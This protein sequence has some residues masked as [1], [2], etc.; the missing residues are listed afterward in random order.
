MPFSRFEQRLREWKYSLG[1]K[2][3]AVGN[4]VI[5]IDPKSRNGCPTDSSPAHKAGT[6]PTEVRVPLVT[7]RIE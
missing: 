5:E 4:A 1:D 3:L 6:V 2:L 7:P